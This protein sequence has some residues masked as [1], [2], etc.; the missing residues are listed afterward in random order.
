MAGRLSLGD[1]LYRGETGIDFVG[2]RR[3][4][5]IIS[6]V[7][8]L[9]SL[10]ALGFRGLNLGIEFQGGAVYSVPNATCSIETARDVASETTGAEAIVT[11]TGAGII[12][13]QTP[14]VDAAQSQAV[15]VALADAC[16]VAATD[17]TVQV[18]GP[19]WGAEIT[20]KGIQ[21]LVVFLVLV[22]L[23]LAI[24]FEWRFAIA[25]L[26][27]LIH[28]IVLTVGIYAITGLQVTPATLIGFL[29]ILGYS[30]YDTVVVF[31]KVKED[32]KGITAQSVMTY[33]EA[34]NRAVN[35][36]LVRSINTTI[37]SLLPVVA[38]IVVGAGLLGAGTL[39]DLAVALAVG[40]L[41]GVYSSIFIATPI[42]V[43]LKNT[44]PDIKALDARVAARR[45]GAGRRASESQEAAAAALGDA[46][47]S[48]TPVGTGGRQQPKRQPRSKRGKK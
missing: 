3:T 16:G 28:D 44:Q 14:P 47:G 48:A 26:I 29:T 9:I 36:V 2:R 18:V 22:S 39:L 13:V 23:F 6:G 34:A 43:V 25:A 41:A 8:V 46:E 45:A 11:E 12:R 33:G 32:T 37:T 19:T 21:A 31:D 4:W 35:Q 5:F 7:F 20:A 17:I 40:M 38:I 27:A 42:A 1:R 30:L 24:Y 10:A 15:S